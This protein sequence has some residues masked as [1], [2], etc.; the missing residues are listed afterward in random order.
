MSE[1]GDRIESERRRLAEQRDKENRLRQE[2]QDRKRESIDV[3]MAEVKKIIEGLPE[4]N[5]KLKRSGNNLSLKIGDFRTLGPR[6]VWAKKPY[7]PQDCAELTINPGPSVQRWH[8]GARLYSGFA[9]ERSDEL[10]ASRSQFTKSI[11]TDS[12]DEL[13]AWFEDRLVP[14]VALVQET[15]AAYPITPLSPTSFDSSSPSPRR[16][17]EPKLSEIIA[18]FFTGIGQIILYLLL[19]GLFGFLAVVAFL[20]FGKFLGWVFS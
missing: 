20:V 8:L 16:A 17:T 5:F 11:L 14:A 4:Q 19:L 18:G 10:D 6:D 2:E 1:L 15:Q 7:Q 9:N 3:A 12:I 13:R